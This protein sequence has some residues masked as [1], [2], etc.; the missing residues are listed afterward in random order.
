MIADYI[1]LLLLVAVF[2]VLAF[3]GLD[4]MNMA[5]IVSAWAAQIAVSS[6]FYYWKS[7]CEKLMRMPILL[8]KELPDDMREKADPNQIIAS[9]LG[10][11]TN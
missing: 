6:G 10:I 2:V 5:I 8:L 3:K 7:K 9:V 1:I 11:G 4:T